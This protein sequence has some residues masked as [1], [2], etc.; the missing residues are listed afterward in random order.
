[1]AEK[2]RFIEQLE[3]EVKKQHLQET[4]HI[5]NSQYV[6]PFSFPVNE[7]KINIAKTESILQ[8]LVEF[9]YSPT[10]L[11]AYIQCPLQFYWKFIEKI[12]VAEHFDQT[13]ES[14]VI[15]TVI[16]EVLKEIF[17][18][19]QEKSAKFADILANF[20]KNVDEI[21]TRVFRT[22]PEI[23]N[24]DITQGKLFLVYQVAKKSILDY[25]DVIH[26]EWKISPFQIIATEIPL[27]AEIE[28]DEHKLCLKGTADRIEIRDNKVTVLDYKTGSVDAKKLK[29]KVEDFEKNFADPE[30]SQ[31]FQLLCYAC[32]YKNN[33]NQTLVQTTEIQCGII[34]F[35]Q[36]YQQNEEYIFYAEVNKDKILTKE[37]LNMFEEKLK[38]I[39]S[40]ILDEKTAFCQTKDAD[41][42]K[43]CDYK[44]ICIL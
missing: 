40:A 17:T 36:L 6:P 10:S 29:S 41:N 44:A 35:Q 8:K 34:A 28:V 4:I 20:A 16:H 24:E 11:N 18:A 22:Q 13:N 42:C 27:V 12:T 1:L 26:E 5:T 38:Q 9:K 15:G 23:G 3:F 30:Y 31:L 39:F 19:L 21:L 43:Y 37:I 7:T 2:S 25:I 14:A 32:L 33:T